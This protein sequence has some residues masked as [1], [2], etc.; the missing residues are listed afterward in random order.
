MMLDLD[1]AGIPNLPG[2]ACAGIPTPEVFFA[3]EPHRI[4]QARDVCRRC[5]AIRAC[6]EWALTHDEDG[7]WAATTPQQRG[8][9]LARHRKE[10]S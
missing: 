8:Q 10:A 3:F 5:P 9:L 6:L 4:E 1:P 2:A 7:I